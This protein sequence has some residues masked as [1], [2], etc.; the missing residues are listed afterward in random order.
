MAERTEHKWIEDAMVIL[1]GY[2]GGKAVHYQAMILLAGGGDGALHFRRLP[3]LPMYPA[4]AD[5][6]W[7]YVDGHKMSAGGHFI[8]MPGTNEACAAAVG[9]KVYH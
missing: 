9:R 7:I 6:R 3:D 5:H 2:E 4:A 1:G 8:D